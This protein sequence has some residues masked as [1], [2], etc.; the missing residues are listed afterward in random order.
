MGVKYMTKT[1]LGIFTD[2]HD[3]EDAVTEF[4]REG[5]RAK[6]ISLVMSDT[7]QAT[8]VK[9]STGTNV[10]EGATTGAAT[11]GIIGGLTGLLVGIGVVTI[12]GVGALLI[13]G[14]LA[15][16]LGLTGTAAITVSAA[17]TGAVAG[18]LLGALMGL[19]LPEEDAR[20]Y[21]ERIREG[22]ILLAVPATSGRVGQVIDILEDNGADQIRSVS[23]SVVEKEDEQAYIEEERRPSYTPG[24]YMYAG[25]KGGRTRKRRIS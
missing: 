14:P 4:A 11:G 21:E 18:G 22:G 10:A 25:V 3:A 17:A 1:V 16:A 12:P 5:F 9:R 7:S 6:D 2:R 13:G 15:A 20:I 24:T 8:D 19:G 23:N